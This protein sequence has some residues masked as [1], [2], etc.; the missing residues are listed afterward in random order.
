MTRWDAVLCLG[1]VATPP[2]APRFAT[3]YERWYDSPLVLDVG[4]T[5]CDSPVQRAVP[6][7]VRGVVS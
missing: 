1:L 5:E 3:S 2:V 6:L 4:W 7:L